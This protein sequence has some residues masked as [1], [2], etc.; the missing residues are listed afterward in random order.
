VLA[1]LVL[2]V[3]CSNQEGED[4]SSKIS[5]ELSS[6]E[7]SGVHESRS[8]DGE[9]RWVLEYEDTRAIVSVPAG[10][11]MSVGTYEADVSFPGGA[12]VITGHREGTISGAWLA[13]LRGD[14]KL[15]LIIWM[16][17]SGSGSY[18]T[19]A[20]YVQDNGEFLSVP[21]EPLSAKQRE[22]YMGHDEY[23]VIDGELLRTFP[24]YLP[25]D[26]NAMPTGGEAR[27]EY[28][29]AGGRWIEFN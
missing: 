12:Q 6:G 23:G 29:F 17:S 10:E 15:D 5:S 16:T 13:D 2:G 22:G 28:S 1:I 7:G 24:V 9:N 25:G 14:G 19:I 20:L 4:V 18:G 26:S 21:L 3:G 27:L 11:G 8:R